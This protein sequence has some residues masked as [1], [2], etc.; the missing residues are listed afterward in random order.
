MSFSFGCV[1][2]RNVDE[3]WKQSV[4]LR[5]PLAA[6][7]CTAPR[8]LRC[9]WKRAPCED[10][11]PRRNFFPP[12]CVRV[13][14]PCNHEVW[15]GAG[16]DPFR[17]INML[18]LK[19]SLWSCFKSY[20]N[21]EMLNTVVAKHTS[22]HKPASDPPCSTARFRCVGE[23]LFAKGRCTPG[24]ARILKPRW[25]ST[26]QTLS[27]HRLIHHSRRRVVGSSVKF[28]CSAKEAVADVHNA[29]T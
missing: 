8:T 13:A 12:S 7:S 4:W 28:G 9:S 23:D 24:E 27:S 21:A 20:C 10:S 3:S 14:H 19:A 2:F 26:I 17:S 16:E 5:K 18:P 1:N 6:A 29:C 22:K 11:R 15:F 25:R